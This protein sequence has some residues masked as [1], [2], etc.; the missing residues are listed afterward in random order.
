MSLRS[1]SSALSVV[2]SGDDFVAGPRAQEVLSRD[3]AG[4]ALLPG[5]RARTA[6]GAQMLVTTSPLVWPFTRS[7]F[8]PE[9]W[10]KNQSIPA[11]L[12]SRSVVLSSWTVVALRRYGPFRPPLRLPLRCPTRVA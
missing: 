2:T 4:L 5:R 6:G 7:D 9:R 11:P 10:A 1:V 3:D 8:V 12:Y